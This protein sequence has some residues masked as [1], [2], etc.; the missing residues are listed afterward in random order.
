M[1]AWTWTNATLVSHSMAENVTRLGSRIV[2]L[3]RKPLAFVHLL[4]LEPRSNV[5]RCLQDTPIH[6]SII[7]DHVC[8]GDQNRRLRL[9]NNPTFDTFITSLFRACPR[10][11]L[12]NSLKWM[13]PD[14]A[15][16][17]ASCR[18]HGT[19]GYHIKTK[20]SGVVQ[21]RLYNNSISRFLAF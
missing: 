19:A 4:E 2:H 10:Q 5:R 8:R 9:H 18:L 6:L 15:T 12:K 7:S 3:L 20:E 16:R 21:K 11:Y 1:T 14:V 17:M 13:Y